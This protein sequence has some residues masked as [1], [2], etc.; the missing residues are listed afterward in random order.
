MVGIDSRK[1]YLIL[2]GLVV[3]LLLALFLGFF[4]YAANPPTNF[5]GC[6]KIY[7]VSD[8]NHTGP[9]C[10]KFNEDSCSGGIEFENSCRGNLTVVGLDKQFNEYGFPHNLNIT[11]G[12]THRMSNDASV[13]NISFTLTYY[14]TREIS[15]R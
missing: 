9:E 10:L 2:S 11:K 7:A 14:I 13:G 8:I 4:S 5:D 12:E 3:G 15:T 6:N 1:L